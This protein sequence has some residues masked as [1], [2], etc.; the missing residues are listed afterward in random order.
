MCDLIEGSITFTGPA[1]ALHLL[2]NRWGGLR[3]VEQSFLQPPHQFSFEGLDGDFSFH[4]E[5]APA[6]AKL[7]HKWEAGAPIAERLQAEIALLGL[8]ILVEPEYHVG[9]CGP[10]P[11]AQG[12]APVVTVNQQAI[13]RVATDVPARSANGLRIAVLDSGDVAGKPLMSDFIGGRARKQVADDVLGHG[14]AV[15]EVIRTIKPHADVTA[16]RVVSANRSTSYELLCAMTYALWSEMFDVIN[17]SLS[18]QSHDK[19]MNTLGGSLSMVLDICLNQGVKLPKVVAAAGNTS[20][21]QA[22][23]YPARL[24]GSM[25]VLA[26][27]F[28]GKP[29]SYNVKVPSSH[30]PF[31]ATGGDAN[32]NLGSIT[33]GG[34]RA[35]MFG[36]SYAAAVAT[37]H[38]L[39]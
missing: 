21:G 11:P 39:P 3:T 17:V 33:T 5:R 4:N 10:V 9:L 13:A 25:V 14:T 6:V 34:T 29:A 23:G 28:N 38:L 2:S 31:H 27:G 30:M 19:C 26:W 12:N 37:A 24:P 8:P 16:L 22:F 36:T 7:S 32:D 20:T 1:H 35:Y 18:A 15:S